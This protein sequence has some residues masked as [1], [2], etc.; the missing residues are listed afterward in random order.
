MLAWG[1]KC[2]IFTSGRAAVWEGDPLT[3][4]PS[5]FSQRKLGRGFTLYAIVGIHIYTPSSLKW[6]HVCVLDFFEVK[7]EKTSVA[8]KE[9]HSRRCL[10]VDCCKAAEHFNVL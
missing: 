3:S 1:L 8:V 9:Q 4:V 10:K 2:G 6:V 7:E 5:P